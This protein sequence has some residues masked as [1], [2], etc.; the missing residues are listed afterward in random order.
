AG[1]L[2][3]SADR[4]A[5]EANSALTERIVEFARTQHAL[6]AARR[7]DPERSH[8]GA[9]LAAQHGATLRLLL[10]QIPGQLVFS[11]ASQLA[12]IVLA[13]TTVA[14]AGA[15]AV[16]VPEAI[17]LIVV[18]VR[19]LEPFTI[20]AELSGGVET[21]AITLRRIG[22]VLNAP[23]VAAGAERT[24]LAAPPRIT[25]RGVGFRYQPDAPAVLDGLDLEL[26]PGSTT[27][28]VGPS[29]SGKSTVLALLAGLHQPS[30]GSIHFDEV[31]GVR[32]DAE[33]RRALVSVVFQQPYLF[34]GSIRENMLVGDPTASPEA[35][36]G[37][38]ALARVDAV[39]AHLP[40]GWDARVG[41]AGGTLSGGERQRVS[42]ARALLK[43]APVLL[44]DEA[45]SALDTEN[46]AAISGALSG[47]PTPRTRV[48]VA[49]R[50]AS[51]RNADRILFLDEGRIIEDGSIAELLAADGRFAEFWRQQQAAGGWR[52]GQ[53]D[54]SSRT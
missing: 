2:G 40:D 38:G 53:R 7:V 52:L 27:A 49:H 29:G 24:G 46:E 15:G 17:G 33:A 23:T 25:L 54:P 1:R 48:I 12:L 31:D 6:R 10:M 39:A 28:I 21:S 47:D 50:L 19:Y 26:E 44:V 3:R 42:I 37:A 35:L 4:A 16:T 8:V 18:I 32:F 30:E 51:I 41:E 22:E 45:T 20:L 13:G 36:A 14:L 5:A 43:P 9:A 34:D 11:L